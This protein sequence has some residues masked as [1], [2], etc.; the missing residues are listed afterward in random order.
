LQHGLSNT[1]THGTAKLNS[2]TL[3]HDYYCRALLE[4]WI[5]IQH[6]SDVGSLGDAVVQRWKMA[7]IYIKVIAERCLIKYVF[8]TFMRLMHSMTSDHF[9]TRSW[10]VEGSICYSYAI[11]I[12]SVCSVISTP[13]RWVQTLPPVGRRHPSPDSMYFYVF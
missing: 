9:G 5:I 13:P 4:V 11:R 1:H 2:L 7:D 12:L 6:S 8:I 10:F 3:R